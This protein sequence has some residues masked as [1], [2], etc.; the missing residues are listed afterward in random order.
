MNWGKG[1]VVSFLMF[2]LFLA[3]MITIMMRQD[4]GLVSDQY[5]KE[6]LA[7]QEQYERK[8]N[9]NELEIIPQIV[10]EQNEYIKL[11][12]P[13]S[14]PVQGEL[15][16]FRPSADKLDRNFVIQ[17]SSD[18]VQMF[19]VRGL[20]RGVYRAKLSWTMSGKGYYL[21]KVLVY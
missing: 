16:L 19:L 18:S 15:R 11:V 2:A 3:V 10:F 4:I 7:Y 8:Q 5:H 1:I 14:E 17:P 9:T 13:T 21:E 20:E 12:F 6:D